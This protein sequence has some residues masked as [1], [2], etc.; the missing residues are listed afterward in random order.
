M[1]KDSCWLAI[2]SLLICTHIICGQDRAQIIQFEDTKKKEVLYKNSYALIIGIGEYTEGWNNL[3]GALE[4]V[5]AVKISLEKQGFQVS[6]SINPKS[7][8][9]E[10]GV[11]QFLNNYGYDF[12]NRL[13]IYFAGHGHTQKL[14][15]NREFG[16]LIPSDAPLPAKDLIGFQRKAIS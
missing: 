11:R 2:L 9:L 16:Y 14:A 4:D 10:E 15:D 5:K 7:K 13:L 6:T 12:N 1:K 8:D 3:P